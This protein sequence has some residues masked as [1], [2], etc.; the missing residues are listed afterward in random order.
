M[1]GMRI[2]QPI[3]ILGLFI[4]ITPCGLCR[5]SIFSSFRL[6][7]N[8][9]YDPEQVEGFPTSG[10]DISYIALLHYFIKLKDRQEYGYYNK[11][12]D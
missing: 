8:L 12:H 11:P 9:S 3:F 5:N 6:V 10:N 4:N 2:V 1:E 7:Q